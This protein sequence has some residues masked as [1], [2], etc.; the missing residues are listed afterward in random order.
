MAQLVFDAVSFSYPGEARSAL[1]NCSV[2]IP[3]GKR[4]AVIGRN[5][6]GKSTFFLHCN[7]I[8][9]PLSGKLLLDGE[10]M[11]YGRSDIK[12][13]RQKVGIV[14]QNADDQL[15]S[16]SIEQDISFG[17]LNLGLPQA[18]VRERVR[19][20]AAQCELTHLLDKPIHALSGGEKARVA[21]AGVLAMRPEIILVDEPTAS[22]DPL[23]RQQ[24]FRI[25]NQLHAA[26][27]TIIVATHEYEVARYW[28][29]FVIVME[30]GRV[31]LA[32]ESEVVFS[33]ADVLK[34]IG[35]N[36][37]WYEGVVV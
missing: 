36:A 24:V 21:L 9:R 18:E 2:A 25:F 6:S 22:L 27:K 32:D 3:A 4:V 11:E 17:P 23:M 20:V 1:D 15:F 19:E 8:L 29:D 13:I 31:L 5:G 26:G 16:A 34:N 33:D 37:P 12:K 7:G 35:L 14:F 28:A 10:V 30:K